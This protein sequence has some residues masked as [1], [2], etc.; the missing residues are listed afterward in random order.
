MHFKKR[1]IA[2]AAM[3]AM[4][5]ATIYGSTLEIKNSGDESGRLSWF[6]EKETIYFWY[7]DETMADYV[8]G[9]AVTFGEQNG[10]R[11]I[12]VHCEESEY[13]E[14]INEASLH[15]DAV[16]DL[17]LISNDSLEKAYLAG[18]ASRIAD[19][20]NICTEEN[21]PQ[22]AL[23]AVTYHDT[24]V[25]YPMSFETTALLYNETYFEEWARQQAEKEI[26]NADREDTENAGTEENARLDEALV[27]QK[28]QEYLESGIPDTVSEILTF[29]DGFDVPETV[30]CIM[31]W[32]VSDVMY[33]YW[34][35]G[36]YL[37]VGGECGDDKSNINLSN[38]RL[39]SCLEMYQSLHQFFSIESES[40]TYDSVI[41]DFIDG[42]TVFTIGTTD[43][44]KRLAEAKAD[45]SLA[46]EYG[47]VTMPA[48]SEE[49]A[50]RS[51]SI[52]NA[53]AINGYSENKELANRF[54]EYLTRDYVENLYEKTGKA[55]AYWHTDEENGAIQVFRQEY[56]KSISAPKMM[57]TGN[58]WMQMEVLFTKL[59]NGEDVTTLMQNLS[60]QVNLQLGITE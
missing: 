28:T 17:Y 58:F 36:A 59:W 32:D 52:T 47:I 8:N 48:V 40:I 26:A 18:L 4:V 16:P 43:A 56:D 34:I 27:A 3:V 50:S 37:T 6:G 20:D 21:F 9:A 51:M 38:D 10:V 60:E 44:V 13:L 14:A 23:S 2:V 22:A 25:A 30:E 46:Y 24:L 35:A 57:E 42:K 33:N 11:V 54:A 12:P 53:I 1:L 7:A 19:E 31:E 45:G 5:A 55:A 39:L 49:L 29:A 41:Q 15:S